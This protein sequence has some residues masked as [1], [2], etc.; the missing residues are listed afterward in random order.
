MFST[1]DKLSITSCEAELT[2]LAGKA[3][4][5]IL[6][7]KYYEIFPKIWV[8]EKDAVALALENNEALDLKN[9]SINCLGCHIMADILVRPL[10]ASN[11][12]VSGAEVTIST[13]DSCPVANELRNS[14]RLINI[15]KTAST[16]AHGV[17]NP[18]NAIKGA[19]IYLRDKYAEETT[20][21]EFTTIIEEEISRLDS[22]VSRFLSASASET[23]FAET[24]INAIVKKAEIVT[25]LQAHACNIS[26]EYNYGNIPP[27][28][29]DYFQLEQAVLNVI[30]NAIDA[31]RAG[32][33]LE[34][35]TGT[36][37]KD[38]KDYVV[39]EISDTGPG[40]AGNHVSDLSLP[41]ESKG[42]GFGLFLTRE[43]LQYLQGHLEIIS[44]KSEGTTVQLFLPAA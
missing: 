14:Q 33:S 29:T 15:G 11:G 3:S 2:G 17:R 16:L 12:T 9:Y 39:I 34:V 30:N 37:S 28:L 23:D 19:V 4:S 36:Q 25:S 26:T 42:K 40:M 1:D 32:G 38:G 43:I 27:V 6:G 8:G 35:T 13:D 24:D 22:F 7:K 31:M 41:S 21:L 5:E 10:K 18:L 44:G 20:L